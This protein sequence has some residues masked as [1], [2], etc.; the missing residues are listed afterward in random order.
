MF[1]QPQ[2]M[3]TLKKLLVLLASPRTT[4]VRLGTLIRIY[5]TAGAFMN[6]IWMHMVMALELLALVFGS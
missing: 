5:V 6:S 1:P 2:L 4:R 3:H